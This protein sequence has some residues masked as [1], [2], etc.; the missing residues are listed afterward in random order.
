MPLDIVGKR[1][2]AC[3]GKEGGGGEGKEGGGGRAAYIPWRAAMRMQA[4]TSRGSMAGGRPMPLDM[5][6][7]TSSTASCS[8]SSLNPMVLTWFMASLTHSLRPAMYSADM[9]CSHEMMLAMGSV[10]AWTSRAQ[11]N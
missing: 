10:L 8:T 6:R 4:A 9:L 3:E 5:V 1:R 2:G 11:V 7:S